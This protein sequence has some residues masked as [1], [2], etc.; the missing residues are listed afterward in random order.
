MSVTMPTFGS[1]ILLFSHN[2]LLSCS[3]KGSSSRCFHLGARLRWLPIWILWKQR[4]NVLIFLQNFLPHGSTSRALFLISDF[5]PFFLNHYLSLG[6]NPQGSFVISTY[7]EEDA[8]WPGAVFTITWW[9]FLSLSCH[10]KS[11]SN[12]LCTSLF[13]FLRCSYLEVAIPRLAFGETVGLFSRVSVRFWLLPPLNH[14][15]SIKTNSCSF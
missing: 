7:S 1:M 8:V 13:S 11:C 6:K 12:Q 15:F 5:R 14:Q 9:M 3:A 10:E 4:K 2:L